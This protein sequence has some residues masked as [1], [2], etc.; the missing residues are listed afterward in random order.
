[1]T[2]KVFNLAPE[3][4]GFVISDEGGWLPG[5]Y[6]SEKAANLALLQKHCENWGRLQRLQHESDGLI[7]I[8]Q[9]QAAAKLG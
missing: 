6:E 9:L 7:T 5:V 3:E 2:G 8:E 1:M 4:K